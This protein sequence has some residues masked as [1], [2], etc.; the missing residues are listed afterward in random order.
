MPFEVGQI[1][2]DYEILGV[3]GTGGMGRVYRVR[4]VISNR[5]EAMKVLLT[6][7]AAEAELG[8]RFSGEIKTLGR[9]DHPNIA[10]LHTAFKID[11]QLVMIM[12]FVEGFTLAA[13]AKEGPI[14]LN[15]VLSYV[16]QM[17]AALSY[18]HQN[19]VIHR[20]IKPS[21]VMVTPHGIVKLMDFGIAKSNSEPLLTR[22]GTTMGSMLYMSPEQ[23]RGATVDARSDLYSVGVVLYEITSGHRPFEA[24]NTYA[25]LEAQLNAVPKAPIELNPALP[26]ALNDIIMTALSKEPGHRFQSAEAFR[27]ALETVRAQAFAG[28]GRATAQA[29]PSQRLRA[30][31]AAPTPRPVS[32]RHRGL[33]MAVGAV[34]CVCILVSAAIIVP[35]FRHSSAASK[36]NEPIVAT[37]PPADA[38]AQAAPPSSTATPQNQQDNTPPQSV[39]TTA[40]KNQPATKKASSQPAEKVPASQPAYIAPTPSAP[41]PAPPPTAEP[42]PVGPSQQELE[43]VNDN[44]IKL[45]ARADAVRGSVERLRQEQAASGLGLSQRISGSASRLDSYLQNADRALQNNDV[46]SAHRY[47]DNLEK[48][49]T[50]LEEKFGK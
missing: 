39:L 33:W 49:L 34:S 18:A 45:H 28:E 38:P 1:A 9:L 14:P 36:P 23:V 3:L 22:P 40:V 20:D 8:E 29:S 2:S 5:I 26:P 10:R 11:N 44:L 25:I 46:R 37:A 13:R 41:A 19:G 21:N 50:F 12:E 31:S 4:N 32:T 42:Q 6:D 48:E 16:T 17:L 30:P 35:H 7:L 24:E 27:K 43:E 47:M 15:E